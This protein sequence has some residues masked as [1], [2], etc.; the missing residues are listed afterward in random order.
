MDAPKL[1]GLYGHDRSLRSASGSCKL[2][3]HHRNG[4][5]IWVK[6]RT[7][8]KC[9]V[10]KEAQDKLDTSWNLQI[11]IINNY[12]PVLSDWQLWSN[13]VKGQPIHRKKMCRDSRSQA[14]QDISRHGNGQNLPHHIYEDEHPATS[15]HIQPHP[16]TRYH[17]LHPSAVEAT[18]SW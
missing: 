4:G 15:S 3:I 12:K 18:Q 7:S 5:R 17:R 16:A 14:H 11:N 10:E 2:P 8:K 13:P 6:E 1:P 9:K